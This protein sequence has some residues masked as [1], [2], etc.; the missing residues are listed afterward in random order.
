MKQVAG[1]GLRVGKP[2]IRLATCYVLFALLL[3]GGFRPM[4]LRILISRQFLHSPGP[5][6]GFDRRPLREK[7]DPT[8]P[9]LRAFLERVRAETKPGETIAL[10]FAQPH[11]MFS[12]AYWR[13]HYVLSGRTVNLPGDKNANVIAYWPAGT[14]ERIR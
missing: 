7:E 9:E 5:E 3:I 2:Y 6:S 14:I 13:A 4:L 8:P 12:F 10:D 11:D 1:S